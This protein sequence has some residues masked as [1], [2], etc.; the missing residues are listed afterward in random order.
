MHAGINFVEMIEW[1]R[2]NGAPVHCI[3][4][5]SHLGPSDIVPGERLTAYSVCACQLVTSLCCL[6]TT[7][8]MANLQ[9]LQSA[10]RW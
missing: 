7:P 3:G 10:M 6:V 2:A 1:L 4:A 9:Q 8:H 5:Q